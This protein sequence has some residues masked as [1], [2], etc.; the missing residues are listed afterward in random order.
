[1]EEGADAIT[2]KVVEMAKGGDVSAARFDMMKSLPG[3]VFGPV[4]Q[5]KP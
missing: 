2:R 4:A 3:T 1:L 5:T